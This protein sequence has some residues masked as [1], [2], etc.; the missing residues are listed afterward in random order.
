MVL[1]LEPS[2]PRSVGVRGRKHRS[3]PQGKSL[4]GLRSKAQQDKFMA[5]LRWFSPPK[6]SKNKLMA[7]LRWF[8]PRE[9]NSIID[10]VIK[11]KILAILWFSLKFLTFFITGR[12]NRAHAPSRFLP[13]RPRRSFPQGKS[14]FG[15]FTRQ[16][17]PPFGFL[18]GS[19]NG[20]QRISSFSK[21]P[22]YSVRTSFGCC[23]ICLCEVRACRIWLL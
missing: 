12:R 19:K 2:Q 7:V 1:Y 10:R 3:F 21:Q 4:F 16:I 20:I 8:L 6:R 9:N 14:L 15:A 13:P 17:F 22:Q 5:A 23:S 18:Y 11:L